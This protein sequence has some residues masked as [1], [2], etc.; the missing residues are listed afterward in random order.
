MVAEEDI[1]NVLKSNSNPK[2]QSYTHWGEKSLF[3]YL[4]GALNAGAKQAGVYITVNSALRTPYNQ[5]R[6]MYDNYQAHGPSRASKEKYLLGL[7]KNLNRGNS[8]DLLAV[9]AE[10]GL[11]KKDRLN[12]AALL[13]TPGGKNPGRLSA[14]QSGLAVDIKFAESTDGKRSRHTKFPPPPGVISAIKTASEMIKM[15]ILVEK[16]HF[17]MSIRGKT[18]KSTVSYKRDRGPSRATKDACRAMGLV[19]T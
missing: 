13:I 14:H 3:V 17:H 16:D 7:Y 19:P 1:T 11:S 15:N 6:I 8:A 12:K 4:L 18:G 10:P 5:A 9:Y 2:S